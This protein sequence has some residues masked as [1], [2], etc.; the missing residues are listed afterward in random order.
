MTRIK[1]RFAITLSLF[2]FLGNSAFVVAMTIG[3]AKGKKL[4]KGEKLQTAYVQIESTGSV[5]VSNEMDKGCTDLASIPVFVLN[6]DRRTDRLQ[7]IS[8]LLADEMAWASKI[9][10]VSAPDGRSMEDHINPELVS[11]EIWQQAM[12]NEASSRLLEKETEVTRSALAL[13]MGHARIWE[14]VAKT[15][16]PFAVVLE[17]D[18]GCLHPELQS[19]LCKLIHSPK[20]GSHNPGGD[21]DYMQLQLPPWTSKFRPDNI[22]EVQPHTDVMTGMYLITPEASRKALR[23][24][25]PISTNYTLD[26]SHGFLRSGLRAFSVLHTAAMQKSDM[27]GQTNR[28]KDSDIGYEPAKRHPSAAL[29][30]QSEMQDCEPIPEKEATHPLLM[31]SVADMA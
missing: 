14:R 23:A 15:E 12:A 16:A 8:K 13:I 17:D 24:Y 3:D 29:F 19:F 7:S 26:A 1:P 11:K 28:D 4:M 31:G 20:D 22:L 18:V 6:L 27:L 10:R 25:I 2:S 30:Q 5:A 21:W 9:C